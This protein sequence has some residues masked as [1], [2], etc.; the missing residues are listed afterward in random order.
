MNFQKYTK[1]TKYYNKLLNIVL[2]EKFEWFKKIELND[3][4]VGNI[5]E[6]K[7]L[8]P[9]GKIYVDSIWGYNQWKEYHY[10]SS[11]P[12]DEEVSFGDII[13]GDLSKEIQ[14]QFKL[15]FSQIIGSLKPKYMCFSWLEMVLV[16][17]DDNKLQENIT[18][19]KQ[20]M[21]ILNE[22]F[23]WDFANEIV[24]QKYSKE[25]YDLLL[26]MFPEQNEI[27]TYHY[28]D[29]LGVPFAEWRRKIH[30]IKDWVLV[31][32]VKVHPDEIFMDEESFQD[33][34]KKYDDYVSGK[35]TKYFRDNDTDPRKTDF[36]KIPPVTL[37]KTDK[38][39]LVNDGMHRVFLAKKMNRPLTA[40][41]WVNKPNDSPFVKEIEKLF[42]KK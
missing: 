15:C 12:T 27:I 18:R 39:Y 2:S 34:A 24:T 32:P 4:Q 29:E 25:I 17:E 9:I 16:E 6:S 23:D 26:K 3:I 19:I 35:I 1:Y 38:G 42:N 37:E 20:M 41:V 33:R 5:Y 36:N 28:N 13:G 22:D 10:D 8:I 21:G 7:N 11:F 31:G 30:D 14:E 40:Y